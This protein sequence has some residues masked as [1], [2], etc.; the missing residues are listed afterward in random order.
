[1]LGGDSLGQAEPRALQPA[2]PSPTATAPAVDEPF[3]AEQIRAWLVQLDDDRFERR[4]AAQR[5]LEATG[6]RALEPVTEQART[7]SLESVTRAVRILLT[8][9]QETDQALRLAALEVLASLESKP[10]EAALAAEQLATARE[11][12]AIQDLQK[13]GA[14]FPEY[15][16]RIAAGQ[17]RIVLGPGWVGGVDG[18]E[19]L[20]QLRH[21]RTVSLHSAPLTE[22]A[23]K[24]LT[25]L[26]A[27]TQRIE[28]YGTKISTQALDQFRQQVPRIVVDVRGGALL[29]VH[30]N[31][32]GSILKVQTGSAAAR[33]GLQQRDRITAFNGE[34]VANFTELTAKISKYQPGDQAT[35]TI[36][37]AQQTQQIQ[38]QFGDWAQ[39]DLSSPPLGQLIPQRVVPRPVLP[40]QELPQQERPP[41]K[42][43]A[44]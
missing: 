7:G 41:A 8:W 24:H 2:L 10:R 4:E 40:A 18:L 33:A 38:V 30:G 29:G 19:H 15:D 11:A 21:L 37:R 26:P 25:Q 22:A 1:L 27:A 31:P 36:V 23:L 39:A 42:P 5:Q 16:Q 6:R 9:S 12:L 20:A 43:S 3:S 28:F 35:L 34:K 32:D 17:L 14:E 44:P 13:L